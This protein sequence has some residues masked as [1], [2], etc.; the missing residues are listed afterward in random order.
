M[1]TTNL[2]P[3]ITSFSPTTGLAGT[4]VRSADPRPGRV[5]HL[6]LTAAEVAERRARNERRFRTL[7][8]SL[9]DLSIEPILVS[10]HTPDR[11]LQAF[12]D[13]TEHRLAQTGRRR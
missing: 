8:A 1:V 11:V 13:W 2:T 4:S 9:R 12:A 10:E 5:T 7:L 3:T 6:R